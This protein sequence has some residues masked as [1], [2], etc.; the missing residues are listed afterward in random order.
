MLSELTTYLHALNGTTAGVRPTDNPEIG[1]L[2]ELAKGARGHF[3]NYAVVELQRPGLGRFRFVHHI[4]ARPECGSPRY[5]PNGDGSSKSDKPILAEQE[6]RDDG[7]RCGAAG[8]E[9]PGQAVQREV[10][11]LH[12]G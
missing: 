11:Q 4:S 6:Q 5:V 7:V 9:G 12:Q 8:Q 1:D 10:A 3:Q 2:A